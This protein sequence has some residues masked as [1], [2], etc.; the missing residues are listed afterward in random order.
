MSGGA[1][2]QYLRD[3]RDGEG[4]GEEG[5]PDPIVEE[6]E[7]AEENDASTSGGGVRKRPASSSG[8]GVLKRPASFWT[9]GVVK[10]PASS[11]GGGV[12]KRPASSASSAGDVGG[13]DDE[14]SIDA[15]RDRLKSRKFDQLFEKLPA[16]VQTDYNDAMKDKTGAKRE[17]ITTLVNKAIHRDENGKLILA[18]FSGTYWQEMLQRCKKKFMR[19]LKNG[20]FLLFSHTHMLITCIMYSPYLSSGYV[21]QYVTF[22][23]MFCIIWIC[24]MY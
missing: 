4:D 8:G 23:W 24:S 19:K 20:A 11:G 6:E 7:E 14:A 17:R 1:I 3:L 21:T 5:L 15:V 22:I 13:G 12:L 9:G 18:D 10:R 16:Y 2:D